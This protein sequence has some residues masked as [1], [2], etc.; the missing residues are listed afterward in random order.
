VICQA[1]WLR[2]PKIT[3]RDPFAA[4][5]RS[6]RSPALCHG[7]MVNSMKTSFA[8]QQSIVATPS[9]YHMK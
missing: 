3:F 2:N 8:Q 7:P 6:L 4:T 1:N 5:I 9:A